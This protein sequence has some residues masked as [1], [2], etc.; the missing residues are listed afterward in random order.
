MSENFDFDAMFA[1]L[2][3]DNA[4]VAAAA[5][6]AV[7]S[8]KPAKDGLTYAGDQDGANGH[9][10]SMY[11]MTLDG[12][13]V[14]NVMID[15]F[16]EVPVPANMGAAPAGVTAHTI[17]VVKPGHASGITTNGLAFRTP[18]QD[19]THIDGRSVQSY[20]YPRAVRLLIQLY[21]A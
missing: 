20:V 5:E 16:V 9:V 18:H 19:G 14:F 13:H 12:K 1:E 8:V 7:A 3:S 2:A 21:V 17:T 6:A 15:N 10:Y 4:D 11:T